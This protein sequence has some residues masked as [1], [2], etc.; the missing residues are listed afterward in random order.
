MLVTFT[1]RFFFFRKIIEGRIYYLQLFYSVGLM[2]RRTNEPS[3]QWVVGPMG[4]R[5]NGSSDQWAVG[6]MGRRTIERSPFRIR[7]HIFQIGT[8]WISHLALKRFRWIYV[9]VLCS[10]L[11]SSLI[12]VHSFSSS[13][14]TFSHSPK[15]DLDINTTIHRSTYLRM[16]NTLLMRWNEPKHNT[17]LLNSEKLFM[18]ILQAIGCT[19][20][21]QSNVFRCY[22]MKCRPTLRKI[23]SRVT[24]KGN[25][26]H[27]YFL[28][29]ILSRNKNPNVDQVNMFF[30]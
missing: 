18:I 30:L 27:W 3:D 4:R 15:N 12:H 14:S 22:L 7:H 20:S 29:P 11:F 16:G 28:V 10:H 13:L 26:C 21:S 1:H 9:H 19:P 23:M 2:S 24:W 8:H 25:N 6:L 5:T 17:Q